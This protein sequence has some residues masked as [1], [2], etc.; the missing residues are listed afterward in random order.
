[1]PGFSVFEQVVAK[2]QCFGAQLLVELEQLGFAGGIQPS[3]VPFKRFKRFVVEHAVLSRCTSRQHHRRN[4]CKERF[5]RQRRVAEGGQLGLYHAGKFLQFGRRSRAQRIEQQ[6]RLGIELVGHALEGHRDRI[7]GSGRGIRRKPLQLS[8]GA[9]QGVFDEP[10]QRRGLGSR[11]FNGRRIAGQV[12]VGRCERT[13][14]TFR[15][16]RQNA[17]GVAREPLR[18][19]LLD[20]GASKAFGGVGRNLTG[21]VVHRQDAEAAGGS[22]GHLATGH[23]IPSIERVVALT[24]AQGARNRSRNVARDVAD[25]F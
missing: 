12:G 24:G 1:M 14:G 18:P 11:G 6:R 10:T 17:F 21:Q 22:E 16:C 20:E 15:R 25:K 8:V 7:K 13:V 5:I 2:G 3:S 9:D 23:R 4:T 19:H